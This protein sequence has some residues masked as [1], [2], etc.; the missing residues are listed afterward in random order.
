VAFV[1]ALLGTLDEALSIP[2]PN[3]WSDQRGHWTNWT[4]ASYIDGMA[5]WIA[6]A[7][8]LPLDRES[9]AIWSTLLPTDG[10]WDGGEAELRQYLTHVASWA[11]HT[12]A[13]SEPW[14]AAAQAMIAAVMYE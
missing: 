12:P 10:I 5:S 3:T 13:T 7:G 1:V 8:R 2:L 9:E 4:L 14:R 11:S 6:D